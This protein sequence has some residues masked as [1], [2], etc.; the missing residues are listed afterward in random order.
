ME[1]GLVH[2]GTGIKP[3]SSIQGKVKPVNNICSQEGVGGGYISFN[4]GLFTLAG[5]G[6]EAT[7]KFLTKFLQFYPKILLCKLLIVMF[8]LLH[9]NIKKSR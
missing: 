3:L 9:I 8:M 2:I 5:V 6:Y 1:K 7:C 4:L